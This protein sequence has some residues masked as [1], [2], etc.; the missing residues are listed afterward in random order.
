M[1]QHEFWLRKVKCPIYFQKTNLFFS[2]TSDTHLIYN[3][4][5]TFGIRPG[6][7]EDKIIL[8][9]ERQVLMRLHHSAKKNGHSETVINQDLAMTKPAD[10][11]AVVLGGNLLITLS[12]I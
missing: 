11:H 4:T 2:K 9:S 7:D 1:Q 3:E 6:R 12:N 5:Q 10:S 8:S